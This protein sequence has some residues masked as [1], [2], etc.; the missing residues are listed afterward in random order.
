MAEQE[1]L[2][3]E[4]QVESASYID[5]A[6]GIRNKEQWCRYDS[7]VIGPGAR[8]EDPGWF[9]NWQQ[10]AAVQDEIKLFAGPRQ[11]VNPAYSNSGEREDWAQMVYG[12][13]GEFL[14]PVTDTRQL[15][16]QLDADL[17]RWWTNEVP[18]ATYLT[19]K[20][21]DTDQ[22]LSIPATYAPAG[23]GA[24]ELRVD[25]AS[26]PTI[27]PGNSGSS[28]VGQCWQWP[29]PLGVPALKRIQVGLKFDRRIFSSIA[30]ASNA[31]GFT[32]WV[33]QDPNNPFNFIISNIANR[34]VLRVG[35]FGPRFVQLRGA[36]SQG[37]T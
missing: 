35:L 6:R 10:F 31:P 5:L 4:G 18:R 15:T 20:L 17:A 3:G 11:N 27:N 37:T 30:Y 1:I 9:N 16:N 32:T 22:I 21:Q 13:W 34:F 14:A 26:A 25:G 19:V 12:M 29:I 24:T 33:G 7:V 23:H 8:D 36:Y 28:Q 2:T